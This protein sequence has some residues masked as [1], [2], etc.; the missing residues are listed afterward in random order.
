MAKKVV[1]H[2]KL[3][4]F[5]LAGLLFLIIVL[6]MIGKDQNLFGSTFVLKTRF[7]NVQGLVPGNNVRYAGIEVG[8]VRS[9][10]ILN[11]TLV[12]VVMIVQNKMKPFIR[13]NAITTIGTDGLMGNKVINIV[14]T[15]KEAAT[16]SEDDVLTSRQGIDSD[17]MLRTLNK[18]NRDIAVVAENLKTTVS[19]INNSTALWKLL[20]DDNVPGDIRTAAYNVKLATVRAAGMM[21]DL[22]NV[23]ADIK[24]GKG[25][26]G[27]IVR[28]T[29]LA[30]K[31]D[32]TID[33]ISGL[34]E[35]AGKLAEI[36]N[37]TVSGLQQDM[38]HGKGPVNAL[39]KDST[40]VLKF[41]NSLDNIEKGT[42]AFNQNMEALKHNFLF[43]SYFRRLDKQKQKAAKDPV[44]LQ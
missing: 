35:E 21:T 17:D 32:E 28:D 37:E 14:A 10:Q 16:V 11:D 7:E 41:N 9:I 27:R 18:T 13:K 2:I 44:A 25:S 1:N 23:V 3:G 8:T 29:I 42:D 19:R 4:V 36:L 34:G 12:E 39:L 40:I 43:R 20:N 24:A 5:V 26:L 22:N 31:L 6:Y 38:N 30:I 33:R 15:R